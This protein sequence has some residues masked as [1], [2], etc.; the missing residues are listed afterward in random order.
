MISSNS[1]L[2]G[3][4]NGFLNVCKKSLHYQA[5]SKEKYT[6]ANQ[7]PFLTKEIIKEIMT[8]QDWEINFFVLDPMKIK[9]H[10]M[11]IVLIA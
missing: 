2:K 7:A 10:I 6:R 3:D 4:L 11:S 1:I 5:S 8:K 9:K